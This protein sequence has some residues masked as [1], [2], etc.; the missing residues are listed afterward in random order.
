[1]CVTYV[2]WLPKVTGGEVKELKN[3]QMA[4]TS[5]WVKEENTYTERGWQPSTDKFYG[6]IGRFEERLSPISEG[7][8]MCF[9]TTTSASPIIDRIVWREGSWHA[10]VSN[11]HCGVG[12]WTKLVA[13]PGNAKTK[14]G[15]F[16]DNGIFCS[17]AHS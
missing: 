17:D 11:A 12:H 6:Y 2:S 13:D 5:R 1:M 16:C 14:T 4:G 3:T 15:A 8:W 9:T 10:W 7:D